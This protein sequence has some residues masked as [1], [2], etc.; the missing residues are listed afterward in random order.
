MINHTYL[1]QR[2]KIHEA[3]QNYNPETVFADFPIL[4]GHNSLTV[5]YLKTEL[6][7][8]LMVNNIFSKVERCILKQRKSIIR[9]PFYWDGRTYITATICS[10]EICREA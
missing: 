6:D 5:Y 2:R 8:Y 7:M 4:K 10:S 1:C 3:K 9:K